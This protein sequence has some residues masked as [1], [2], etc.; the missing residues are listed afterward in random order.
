[1]YHRN[2]SGARLVTRMGCLRMLHDG[3]IYKELT[4]LIKKKIKLQLLLA[5]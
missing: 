5:S 1:M 3:G 2:G 4:Y